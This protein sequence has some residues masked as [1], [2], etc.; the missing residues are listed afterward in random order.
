M[1]KDEKKETSQ[2]SSSSQQSSKSASSQ[3]SI[4]AT[5]QLLDGTFVG[6]FTGKNSSLLTTALV[7]PNSGMEI[8]K[9]NSFKFTAS[10]LDLS[11]LG[12]ESLKIDGVF[13]KVYV[14]IDGNL[15]AANDDKSFNLNATNLALDF[16]VD[17]T[18]VDAK[19]KVALVESLAKLGLVIPEISSQKPAILNADIILFGDSLKVVNTKN[20]TLVVNF[21]GKKSS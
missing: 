2:N 7:F 16:K 14:V 17:G 19:S 9:N 15:T 10:D 1:K 4:T 11:L 3:N 13:P 21:D 8:A 20:S 12:L 5:K 6:K 18:S